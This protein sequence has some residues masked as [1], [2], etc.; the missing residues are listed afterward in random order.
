MGASSRYR[1][2]QFLPY[3][4]RQGFDVD[5]LPLL[6]DKYLE[7]RYATGRYSIVQV[8]PAYVRR[9]F[10]L[11]RRRRYDLI[12]IEKEAFPWIPHWVEARLVSKAVPY[13]VDYDD[14]DFHR[15][16][17]H[18]RRV[19]R[20]LL[21]KK[22]DDTMRDAALVIAGNPYIAERALQ[23]GARSVKLLPTVV[24]LDRYRRTPQPRNH[25][26]TVGWIGTPITAPFLRIV[27]PALQEIMRTQPVRLVAVG[28]GPV[29]L[30]GVP[31]EP[32]PW[33]EETEVPDMQAFDVGIMPLSDT[34]SN[35]GKCGLKLI[36]YMACCR[37]VVGT[38]IGV[39]A[40]IIQH[41]VNGFQAT[42]TTDWVRAL[43]RL[44][45]EAGLRDHMGRAGRKIVEQRYSLRVA[46]PRLADLLRAAAGWEELPESSMGHHALPR[47]FGGYVAGSAPCQLASQHSLSDLR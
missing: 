12:W 5:V 2:Y 40:D 25:V 1:S 44:R 16:D 4:Q 34:P 29:A 46:A 42:T 31:V 27:Y 8:A 10:A 11:Q 22:I 9:C 35:R 43:E 47:S 3:L 37:P 45:A 18:R 14:A 21:G 23:A 13:V 28:S 36:Q 38:P 41:G 7:T 33:S 20:L 30:P 39:N 19:V 24:D 17:T 26:F 15:Y 32:R 6:S